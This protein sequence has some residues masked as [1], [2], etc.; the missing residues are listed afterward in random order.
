MLENRI[1]NAIFRFLGVD[2][3]TPMQ[4][5]VFKHKFGIKKMSTRL[6]VGCAFMI[7]AILNWIEVKLTG[8]IKEDG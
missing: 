4:M 6:K 2:D 1:V 8:E 7:P 3:P 5:E